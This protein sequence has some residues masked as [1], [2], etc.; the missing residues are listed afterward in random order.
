M[1]AIWRRPAGSGFVQLATVKVIQKVIRHL[2][3]DPNPAYPRVECRLKKE[4]TRSI[5]FRGHWIILQILLFGRAH[6]HAIAQTIELRSNEA[7]RVGHGSL[8]AALQ[9]LLSSPRDGKASPKP[10]GAL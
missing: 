3:F 1:F 8:Y 2:T 5:C 9:R 7:P 4:M 6:G 10:S